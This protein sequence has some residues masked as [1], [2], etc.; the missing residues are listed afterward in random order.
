MADPTGELHAAIA[1]AR[2]A[3]RALGISDFDTPTSLDS[4]EFNPD[5]VRKHSFSFELEGLNDA[6]G[7]SDIE[8]DLERI[9]GVKARIVFAEHRAW[10]TAPESVGP[11]Q[12]AEIMAKHG[13]MARLTEA[14]LRRRLDHP[15]GLHPQPSRRPRLRT[16]RARRQ[17]EKTRRLIEREKR[18]GR[19]R[20]E[21]IRHLLQ[22][23]ESRDVLYTARD[24]VTIPRLVFSTILAIP[25]IILH[26]VVAW[27][28]PGWQWLCLALAL[29]VVVWGAWPFHRAMLG[30]L[31][32]GLSALDASSSVAIISAWLWSAAMLLFT[33]AGEIGWL[34]NPKLFAFDQQLLMEGE[35]YLDVACGMT[36]VLLAGRLAT[37]RTRLSLMDDLAQAKPDPQEEYTV[38]HRNQ[39]TGRQEPEKIPLQEVNV[40]DDLIVP[41]GHIIPVD[42]RVVGGSST[43]RAGLIEGRGV[44]RRVKVNDHVYAGSTAVDGE[45][46]VRVIRTGHLTRS[47]VIHRW[48]RGATRRQNRMAWI[49]TTSASWLIPASLIVAVADFALWYLISGNINAAFTTALAILACVGPVSLALSTSL[50]LRHGIEAAARHGVLL[51]DGNT[52]RQ[53]AESGIV[54]FNRVGTL[55]EQEMS[56]ETVTADHGENPDLV[57][58]IAGA[59]CME[60]D[61]PSSKAIVHAARHSRDHGEGG[62][63]IPHWIEVNHVSITTDGTFTGMLTLP[64]SGGANDK[65]VEASLWRPRTMA[66]LTGRLAAAAVSG[67]TPFIV[68]WK[69]KDRGVITLNDFVKDDASNA[70]EDLSDLGV[71]TMMLS[72]DTYPV[73]RR[74]A[75]RIGVASVLAGIEPGRKAMAV[76]AVHARGNRV[77]MVG[78]S[79]VR[80]CLHVADVG[81]CV[82]GKQPLA[83]LIRS[84]TRGLDVVVLRTDVSAIPQT[85]ALARRTTRLIEQNIWFA[86]FYNVVA[87]VA[88]ISGILHPMLATVLMISSSLFIEWRSRRARVY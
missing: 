54:I 83:D 29:P 6:P 61:H 69:G 34:S 20:A 75:D 16:L 37:R 72:R 80:E 27:Q 3:A 17:A 55:V 39:A 22:D 79:S 24:L 58:R 46:K 87:M 14:S 78:D 63:D 82:V 42:G 21:A 88:A 57:L 67:G 77:A 50:A 19:L 45:L 66:D 12:L 41:A 53:L 10:I 8:S 13:V 60:S 15:H 5:A 56:V 85:M 65:H 52:M 47:A 33:P 62:D 35:I 73:A 74:F 25:V 86:W 81:I 49:S 36:V 31:R 32:R 40:G 23:P 9:P 4:G 28:F 43:V 18:A 76:R 68:R 30:G 59:L 11:D 7:I 70:I 26:Y 2:Q 71:E 1:E 84:N 51:R 48:V 44:P 64:T 38:V